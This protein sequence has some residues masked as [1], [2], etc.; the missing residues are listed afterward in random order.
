MKRYIILICLFAGCT[1]AGNNLDAV[2]HQTLFSGCTAVADDIRSGAIISIDE[3]VEAFR[4]E[5]ANLRYNPKT[6]A[7][8]TEIE[9]H[10][11][12]AANLEDAERKLRKE[13]KMNNED[14]N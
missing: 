4:M 11:R 7:I 10:I 3:A 12:T 2:K 8:V 5:K 6:A 13:L 1:S 14:S 9:R